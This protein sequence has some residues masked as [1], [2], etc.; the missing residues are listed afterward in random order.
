MVKLIVEIKKFC[1][2]T[3]EELKAVELAKSSGTDQITSLRTVFRS[4]ASSFDKY[5][6]DVIDLLDQKD[7]EKIGEIMKDTE[8]VIERC[9][10]TMSKLRALTRKKVRSKSEL[11]VLREELRGAVS[12]IQFLQDSFNALVTRPLKE[13]ST[14]ANA[15]QW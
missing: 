4:L 2:K 14:Y 5:N 6:E 3:A 13:F 11:D 1:D 10:V 7:K 15:I 8:G 9:E 12:T